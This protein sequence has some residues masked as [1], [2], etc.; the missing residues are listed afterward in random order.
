MKDGKYG[1]SGYILEIIRE[2]I[3]AANTINPPKLSKDIPN[4]L[5]EEFKIMKA[6]EFLSNFLNKASVKLNS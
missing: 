3:I 5:T 4:H 6:T 1:S 2:V